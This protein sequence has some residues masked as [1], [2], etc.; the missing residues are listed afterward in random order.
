[1]PRIFTPPRLRLAR[2][3]S[4]CP[5]GATPALLAFVVLLL[6]AP[7]MTSSPQP[8]PVARLKATL[9]ALEKNLEEAVV[10]FWYPRVLDRTHGG[11]RVAFDA[12]GAP[13]ADG[14]KMIV[15]QARM[16]WLFAR[17]ARAGHRSADMR[18]AAAHGY[19][20]L[21]DRMW[22]RRHGGYVWEV[23]ETGARVT[24]ATKVIY[25]EAF[26]LYA[27]AEYHRATGDPGAL[28]RATELFDLIDGR[29]RDPLYGGYYELFEP[30]W[31]SP[32]VTRASPIGGPPGAKLMN[33]HLHLLEAFAEYYR[34]SGSARARD[35]LFEL[36]AI[37][38]STVVR[39]DLTACTDEYRRDWTP[40]LEGAGAQ[41]SYG[42]DIENIWLLADAVETL[43]QSNALWLDLYRRLFDY[44]YRHGYDAAQGGFFYRGGFNEPA[45]ERQ[46]VWWVE[47][48]ALM[49]ALTMY[50]LTK[51]ATYADVFEQTLRWVMNHQTDWQTGEWFAEVHPDG[52]TTGVKA[53]RWKEGYHNGRA[54]I[55]SI[56]I[57]TGLDAR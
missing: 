3:D 45:R 15:T 31:S 14:S 20:F 10:R 22:D 13:A 46:K 4:R 48:E 47:A 21:D 16:L 51:E 12:A 1:M 43:G 27:L 18:E 32:P 8:D 54:L 23:D 28:A 19:R 17:L 50:R 36:V 7:A 41:V 40:I 9:P 44:S 33:T 25:G 42:H 37:Q 2:S 29:A 30:D 49:S 5:A 39:K 11:Y 55:G 53:D 57:I 26:A 52:S 38:G 34:A 35:R 6:Q 24:D 56:E